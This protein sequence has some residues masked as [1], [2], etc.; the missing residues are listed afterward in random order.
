MILSDVRHYIK[1]QRSVTLRDLMNHF[2]VDADALRGMLSI[3]VT[4]GKV[5]KKSAT[6]ECG[7]GC[8]KCDITLVEIY[9]WR[10]TENSSQ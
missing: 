10:N 2:D 7:T 1:M 4:K 9:E 5:D 3:L 6:S 8:C